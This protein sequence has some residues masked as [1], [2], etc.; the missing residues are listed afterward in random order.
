MIGWIWHTC[1]VS[2]D[3]VV[4][5]GHVHCI[6]GSLSETETFTMY[7]LYWGDV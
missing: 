1:T 3:S 7:I 6:G 4:K 2:G 5:L